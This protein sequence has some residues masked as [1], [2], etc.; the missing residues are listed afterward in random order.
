MRQCTAE[1]LKTIEASRAE[2]HHQKAAATQQT[3]YGLSYSPHYLR[4]SRS[5]K[6]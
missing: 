1:E 2:F 4:Q 5:Q 3:A 6:E